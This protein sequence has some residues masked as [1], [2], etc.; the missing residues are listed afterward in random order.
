MTDLLSDIPTGDIHNM[1]SRLRKV[2]YITQEVIY[3]AGEPI[4]PAEYT[5]NGQSE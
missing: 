4:T 1:L 2:V 5:Q 3:G